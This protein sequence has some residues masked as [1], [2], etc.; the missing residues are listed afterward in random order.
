MKQQQ[1]VPQ[2]DPAKIQVALTALYRKPEPDKATK[3]PASALLRL[4]SPKNHAGAEG[5][6]TTPKGDVSEAAPFRVRA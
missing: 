5:A 4:R 2:A 3:K 6:T 1:S